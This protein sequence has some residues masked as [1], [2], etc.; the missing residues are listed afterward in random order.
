MEPTPEDREIQ[1]HWLW[2]LP[3]LALLMSVFCVYSSTYLALSLWPTEI[4]HAQMLAENKANYGRDQSPTQFAPVNA[5]IILEATKDSLGLSLTPSPGKNDETHPLPPDDPVQIAD[6]L[7]TPTRVLP[8]AIVT[9][10]THT[11]TPKPTSEPNTPTPVPTVEP[12]A[13]PVPT[14]AATVT[15]TFVPTLPPANTATATATFV[16]PTATFTPTPQPTSPPPPPPPPTPTSTPIPTMTVPPLP[17]TFTPT[18]SPTATPQC[19]SNIPAGEPNIGLPNGTIAEIGCGQS[20]VVDLGAANAI[21]V[22]GGAEPAYDLVYYEAEDPTASIGLDW[23]IIEVGTSSSG[24]WVPVFYWGNH[25]P[26]QNTNVWQNGY[27]TSNEPDNRSIPFSALYGG[28]SPGV[29]IDV[30]DVAPPNTYQ[31]IRITAPTG[32]DNDAAEVDS[33]MSLP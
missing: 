7:E 23:V 22:N 31:W 1:R 2:L 20:I 26:D 27:G 17:P 24:P 32:G 14:A 16:P 12:S 29:A 4:T 5:Q 30:D 15:A 8:T 11:P 33:I 13:T 9:T 18:P 21:V 10:A 28:N 3:L 25:V 19:S 6:I